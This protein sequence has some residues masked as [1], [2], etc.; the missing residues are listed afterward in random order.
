MPAE[1]HSSPPEAEWVSTTRQAG[2][3]ALQRTPATAPKPTLDYLDGTF[4]EGSDLIAPTIPMTNFRLAS[5]RPPPQV[6]SG[7]NGHQFSHELGAQQISRS[8]S[9]VPPDSPPDFPGQPA[10]L[11]PTFS[12][13]KRHQM[14]HTTTVFKR[15][16]DCLSYTHNMANLDSV[17][18][19]WVW[20]CRATRRGITLTSRIRYRGTRYRGTSCT[21]YS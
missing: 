14:K 20:G 16:G 9:S 7:P 5:P 19:P 12:Q 1:G 4:P 10:H 8:R 18:L 3:N 13:M 11:T 17:Q 21:D 2:R 15:L 6:A